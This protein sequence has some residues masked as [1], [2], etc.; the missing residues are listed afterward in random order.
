MKPFS[1]V[2]QQAKPTLTI[3]QERGQHKLEIAKAVTFSNVAASQRLDTLEARTTPASW[4]GDNTELIPATK[5]TNAPSSGLNQSAVDARV[6]AGVLDFAE[7]GNTDAIPKTKLPS[8]LLKL[9]AITSKTT[10]A[11]AGSTS[12]ATMTTSRSRSW[13]DDKAILV[14]V[15]YDYSSRSR[16]LH[17]SGIVRG[18]DL[19]AG[20][21]FQIQGLEGKNI[22][23]SLIGEPVTAIQST[24]SANIKNIKVQY[25]ILE[26]DFS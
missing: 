24:P 25:F 13:F 22:S 12:S 17:M 26:I 7:T 16:N 3:T 18:V 2:I 23:L 11:P 4:A 5:L 19:I 8:G 1:L 6:K 14:Y 10:A 21:K 20:L 15:E 9:T